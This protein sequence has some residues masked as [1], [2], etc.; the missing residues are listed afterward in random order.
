MNHAPARTS[1]LARANNINAASTRYSVLGNLNRRNR[2]ISQRSFDSNEDQQYP[3]DP[4]QA[5]MP[6]T[7]AVQN[8]IASE[9]D[10]SSSLA[11]DFSKF[12]FEE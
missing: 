2:S 12:L 11:N 1:I 9:V 3:I 7:T 8:Q 10:H 5:H 4:A 6:N